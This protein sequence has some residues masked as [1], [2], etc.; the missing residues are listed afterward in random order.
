ML[1]SL[2]PAPMYLTSS[3]ATVFH[4]RA[5]VK[6]KYI[7]KIARVCVRTGENEL[8]R[9]RAA[10]IRT[11]EKQLYIYICIIRTQPNDSSARSALL[12]IGLICRIAQ[13]FRYARSPARLLTNLSRPANTHGI[14]VYL[15]C[16]HWRTRAKPKHVTLIDRVL[17]IADREKRNNLN[18][19]RSVFPMQ[20]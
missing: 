16:E 20:N 13:L 5:F 8:A 15:H 18:M 2:W 3:R 6:D 19:S 11:R 4:H 17:H 10:R 9:I 1:L 7:R 14:F 12:S